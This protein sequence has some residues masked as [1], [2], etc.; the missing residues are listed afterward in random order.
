MNFSLLIKPASADCNLACEYCFYSKSKSLYPEVSRPRMD[1]KV[2]A[3]VIQSYLQTPQQVHAF[4]WQGGEPL[5]MGEA[6]F[7]R[8]VDLQMAYASPRVEI[9]NSVQTNAILLTD[10]FARLFRAYRFLTGVSLD[11]PQ[12]LH[13][14]ARISWVGEGSHQRAL[15]GI[16]S[17]LGG[18]DLYSGIDWW[19]SYAIVDGGNLAAD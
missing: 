11:G 2:L 5:L 14:S 16:D 18:V 8:V 7:Q 13:D 15:S 19:H 9:S 1:E 10:R 17:G 3:Q 12:H 6:F 4:V